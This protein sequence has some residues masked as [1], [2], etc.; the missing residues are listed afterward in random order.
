LSDGLAFRDSFGH[1]TSPV[2]RACRFW[3]IS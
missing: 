1:L 3:V 2:K